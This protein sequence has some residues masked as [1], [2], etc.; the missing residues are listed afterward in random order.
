M[1]I[2]NKETKTVVFREDHLS[3]KWLTRL[4][5]NKLSIR[6][7]SFN[8]IHSPLRHMYWHWIFKLGFKAVLNY[9][10]KDYLL[11]YNK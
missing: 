1:K 6:D 5:A 11:I 2:L 9:K 10:G 4:N 3:Q 7:V 8:N